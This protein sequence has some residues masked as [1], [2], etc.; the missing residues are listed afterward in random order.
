LQVKEAIMKK[1]WTPDNCPLQ[2]GSV[3]HDPR[4]NADRMVICRFLSYE[5]DGADE[6]RIL[7]TLD[8]DVTY[9]GSDLMNLGFTYYPD[10]PSTGHE[11][12]CCDEVEDEPDIVKLAQCV[13]KG[14]IESK[15]A[16]NGIH[17]TGDNRG[18]VWKDD[19]HDKVSRIIIELAD[20]FKEVK[21]DEQQ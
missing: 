3:V 7:I 19:I 13:F 4:I 17:Y 9:T 16:V 18:G 14:L 21:H 10:W 1:A 15:Y 12:P 5:N 8:S 6:E 2:V 20:I 11:K